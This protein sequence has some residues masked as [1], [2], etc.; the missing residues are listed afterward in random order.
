M[1]NKI[2]KLLKEILPEKAFIL[3]QERQAFFSDGKVLMI[4]FAASD[5]HI[6][7]VAFQY[8]QFVSLSLDYK[9]MELTPQMYGGCGGQSIYRKPNSNDPKEKYLVMKS[10]KIP[11]RKPQ[12]TEKAIL[13]AIKN[14]AHRWLQALKDNKD[15]LMYQN[16][17][18]YDEFLK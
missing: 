5:H 2:E 3:L 15:V 14:F 7:G 4:G 17:V 8:P 9:E 6:N 13:N 12:K 16:I 1:Q 18:N 10:I 11:F